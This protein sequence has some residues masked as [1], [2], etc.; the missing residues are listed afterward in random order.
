M[1]FGSVHILPPAWTGGRRRWTAR[2][3]APTT[4]GSSCRWT[5]TTEAETA[6]LAAEAG[7]LPPGQSLFTLL[8]PRTPSG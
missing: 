4:S 2:S 7:V 6:R 1:L 5:P 8:P 3:A